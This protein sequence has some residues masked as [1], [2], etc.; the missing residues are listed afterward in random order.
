MRA[1]PLALSAALAL[2]A[3]ALAACGG[4]E[5]CYVHEGSVY[6]RSEAEWNAFVGKGCPVVRGDLLLIDDQAKLAEAPALAEVT[7][8]LVVMSRSLEALRLPAL[9]R[10]GGGF[11]LRSSLALAEV[12]APALASVG[13]LWVRGQG[14][15]LRLALPALAQVPEGVL[16]DDNLGLLEVSLPALASTD[17]YVAFYF[18]A[19]LTR[20]HLPAL[21][22]TGDDLI[23]FDAP[24]LVE[25][26]LSSSAI[27]R[28][29]LWIGQ[30]DALQTLALPALRQVSLFL[31]LDFN[32]ALAS[33][34]LPALEGAGSLEVVG[35]PAL[36]EC[37]A[38][39]LR[40][41]LVAAGAI[42]SA[43]IY[44]NDAAALCG[45]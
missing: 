3:L 44:G 20:I 22:R 38:L 40:D 31:R 14:G 29:G 5:P 13:G 10:V 43:S 36:P 9:E 30:C 42:R 4:D 15:P 2:A 24:R 18:N 37:T 1:Q 12:Q 8:D 23:V 16:V 26:D 32:A 45:P 28:G 39:A 6:V 25:L 21:V 11:Q 19:A 27:V 7:G 17:A 33:L 35:N 34:S 41:R